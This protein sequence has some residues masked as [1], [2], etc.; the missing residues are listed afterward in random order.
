[1]YSEI[2]V[3][4]WIRRRAIVAYLLMSFYLFMPWVTIGGRQGIL[5]DIPARRFV[6]FG[7]EYWATD[8]YFLFLIFGMLAFSLFLFTSLFGR[9]WC[10]WACPETVF[11][12]FLFR[13]L[14]RLIEGN[15]S[16]RKRRDD[17]PWTWDKIWRKAVKHGLCACAA[18]VIASSALA[19]FVGREPL[20]RMMSDWPS[21][22]PVQFLTVVIVMLV[23]A[24]QFGWFREQFCTVLCPYARFQSVLMDSSSIVVGYDV[25]RGEP[26][27]KAKLKEIGDC[28][29]CSACVRVCPTGIDIR[30]GLQLECVACAACVDACDKIMGQ[31]GRAKGLIRYDTE[32]RLLGRSTLRQ[33]VRPR[34]FVYAGILGCFV[35]AFIYA[36]TVHQPAEFQVLRG[37]TVDAFSVL[38]DGRISNRLLLRIANKAGNPERFTFSVTSTVPGTIELV[39]PEHPVPVGPGELKTA[40]LFL[41]FEKSML[42]S[43]RLP[44]VISGT[45]E[46][47]FQAKQNFTLLGPD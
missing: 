18:W 11:L 17:G 41:T 44:V 5:L 25:V 15:A 42:H 9:V 26:R 16:Q 10:G 6:F 45:D 1:M 7:E 39:M 23:M 40:P 19:Y 13:P 46:H 3:G 43:G 37:S 30:N 31:L 8:S 36:W 2:V 33:L 12:E 14:E 38:N 32:Q 27:G 24:F 4:A 47:G 20:L 21:H 22:N 35:A 34:P 29:D 28:V